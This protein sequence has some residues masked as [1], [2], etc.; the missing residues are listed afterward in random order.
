MI[1]EVFF[2]EVSGLGCGDIIGVGIEIEGEE[3]EL[4]LIGCM[5]EE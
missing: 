2:L 4:F 1:M 5:F 3:C